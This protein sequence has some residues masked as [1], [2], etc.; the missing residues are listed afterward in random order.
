MNKLNLIYLLV[1]VTILILIF[2]FP[3]QYIYV[4]G[5]SDADKVT[6]KLLN[7]KGATFESCKKMRRV[8]GFDDWD[9]QEGINGC[10]DD[11][12][13]KAGDP[14]ICFEESSYGVS[15][16]IE[17][18]AKDKKDPEIC[19]RNKDVIDQRSCYDE[20]VGKRGAWIV[21]GPKTSE[22][23][24]FFSF[25]DV[26]LFNYNNPNVHPFY[27][28]THD[29][30]LRKFNF[31]I[32]YP[33][34]IEGVFDKNK[35]FG[36]A[37]FFGTLPYVGYALTGGKVVGWK[38]AWGYPQ[39]GFVLYMFDLG[40][41]Q[42]KQFL[43]LLNG[44][45]KIGQEISEFGDS[46]YITNLVSVKKKEVSG[47]TILTVVGNGGRTWEKTW[48]MFA[49][50]KTFIVLE[51]GTIDEPSADKIIDSMAGPNIQLLLK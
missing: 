10:I 3:G 30:N 14:S 19:M 18:I 13:R 24:A 17:S 47:Y 43:E 33:P 39:K 32:Y 5:Y 41:S 6:E 22:E 42:Q 26:P 48:K 9:V 34:Q 35:D 21:D 2:G 29:Y 37:N 51:L 27:E 4:N 49:K 12:A 31:S 16:C 36:D 45:Y 40:T 46:G 15:G 23:C 7:T 11:F 38:S 20:V 28:C 1:G 50:D 44:N 25:D 8:F